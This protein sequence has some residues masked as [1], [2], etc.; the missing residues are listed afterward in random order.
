MVVRFDLEDDVVLCRRSG[1]CRRC[2]RTRS[3]TSRRRP[4]CW[5]ICCVAAKIV[6]LSM[7]SNC[8][9]PS[10][11]AIGDPAGQ[12]L[13]AAMLAPGLGD[14][15]QL[16]VGRVAV[17][18]RE[19]APGSSASRPAT[20]RAALRGSVASA[21]SSS[22]VANRHRDQLEL[23][24]RAEL[25][26]IERQRPDDDLLDG[27]VGQHLAARAAAVDRRRGPPSQYLRSVRTASACRPRSAIAAS[28]LCA[29]GSITPGL[30]STWTTCQSARRRCSA[31]GCRIDE[32]VLA[33]LGDHGALDHAVDQQFAGD[34]LDVALRSRSPWIR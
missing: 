5:R 20:D 3:R 28:A 34:A 29:T 22:S 6:S 1:R 8:R 7:F 14:R 17:E 27:V 4:A 18:L 24:R 23:V 32:L 19:S 26:L 2:R 16:D 21:P 10:V 15:F 13:V 12:R 31:G 30:G 33:D 9:S 25:Q 11:V